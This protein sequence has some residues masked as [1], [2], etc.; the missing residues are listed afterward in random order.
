MSVRV[1]TC[2]SADGGI[3]GDYFGCMVTTSGKAEVEGVTG[4]RNARFLS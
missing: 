4:T 2:V 3:I 1:C